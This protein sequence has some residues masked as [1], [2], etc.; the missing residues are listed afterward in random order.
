MSDMSEVGYSRMPLLFHAGET[1]RTGYTGN[2]V[3]SNLYDAILFN[4]TRIGHGI[5]MYMLIFTLLILSL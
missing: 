5:Y 3:D 2:Q 4:I 1:D